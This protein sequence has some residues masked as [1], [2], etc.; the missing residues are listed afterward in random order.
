MRV[1]VT[2]GTG[3]VGRQV[4]A[5]L[6]Q[7]GHEVRCLL[8]PGSEKKLPLS[9][10]IQ[11]FYGDVTQ[12]NT[13]PPA[14]QSRDAV[15]HL[16]GIIREFPARG[17]TFRKMHLE[18]TAN[19]VAAARQAGVRRYIHMSAL[20]AKTTLVADYHKTKQQAE[21][22][23]MTSGLTYTIL[24]PSIIYG[25]RDAFINLFKR[26]IETLRLVPIIGHGRY[27]LQPI[28]VWQVAQGFAAALETPIPENRS[29]DV[30]GP[31][32]IS[33]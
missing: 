26:Q 12:P 29:Y 24:R 23:V 21:E 8:R 16:V 7:Q 13:L 25:P 3:F 30:G 2:G 28:P 18:A 10:D 22:V 14:M 11:V 33:L 1:L 27:L 15:I 17:I 5:E 9:G 32:P 4:V 20:E 6:L 19:V 31:E